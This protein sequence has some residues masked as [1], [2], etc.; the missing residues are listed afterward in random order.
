MDPVPSQ[1]RFLWLAWPT[2]KG[3]QSNKSTGGPQAGRVAK[4]SE[5]NGSERRWPQKMQ[6]KVKLKI[7][8]KH[9]GY[10][11]VFPQHGHFLYA[12]NLPPHTHKVPLSAQQ[13]KHT[14]REYLNKH[15]RLLHSLKAV[16]SFCHH[17]QCSAQNSMNSINYAVYLLNEQITS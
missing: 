4:D 12:K 2:V 11:S 13:P 5:Q 16:I 14:P 7:Y 1:S 10:F 15:V 6:G 8:T 17:L 9:R 3:W